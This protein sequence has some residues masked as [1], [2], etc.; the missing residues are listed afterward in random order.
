VPFGTILLLPSQDRREKSNFH[1]KKRNSPHPQKLFGA[2]ICRDI[3][4]NEF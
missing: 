3:F 4:Q 1:I 2:R